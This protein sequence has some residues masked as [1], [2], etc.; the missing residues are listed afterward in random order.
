M[1]APLDTTRRTKAC[2]RRHHEVLLYA[3][4]EEVTP[5]AH[6]AAVAREVDRA[7][8]PRRDGN[9]DHH[10]AGD[11][12]GGGRQR[13]HAARGHFAACHKRRGTVLYSISTI[14][15]SEGTLGTYP[16]G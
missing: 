5:E 10:A 2:R 16:R 8:A 14:V 12:P 9:G 6:V 7:R 1:R 15:L 4:L 13:P 3:N 11:L